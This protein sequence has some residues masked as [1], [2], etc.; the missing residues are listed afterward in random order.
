MIARFNYTHVIRLETEVQ[1]VKKRKYCAGH[2]LEY[3]RKRAGLDLVTLLYSKYPNL[4]STRFRIYSV[5]K[6]FHS[7]ER[8]QK[9]ADSYAGFTG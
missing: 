8:I 4:A 1:E 7:E 2:R 3:S 6:N 9:V 5:I